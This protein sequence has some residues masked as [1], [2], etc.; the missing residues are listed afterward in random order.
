MSWIAKLGYVVGAALFV[1]FLKDGHIGLAFAVLLAAM[2]A[3]LWAIWRHI[4][5]ARERE[6]AQWQMDV[7]IPMKLRRPKDRVADEPGE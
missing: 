5:A 7:T 1:L 2:F 3:G 6:A 4:Q